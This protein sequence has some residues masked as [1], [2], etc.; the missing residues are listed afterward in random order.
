MCVRNLGL[1]TPAAGIE[2]SPE[3]V[4][5]WLER[6]VTFYRG[7][8]AGATAHARSSLAPTAQEL[9]LSNLSAACSRIWELDENRLIPG[10]DYSLD[11][12]EGKGSYDSG[13]AA[14]GPLFTHFDPKI[15]QRPTFKAFYVRYPATATSGLVAILLL[16]SGLLAISAGIGIFHG[17]RPTLR[18]RYRPGVAG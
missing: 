16:L 10:V 5:V 6:G 15:L 2:L 7:K 17:N 14:P 8:C 12:Q 4:E 11:L 3:V 13:D 18:T 9:D 1:Q